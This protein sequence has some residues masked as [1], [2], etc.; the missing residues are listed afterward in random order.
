MENTLF[1]INPGVICG[2]DEAG[3]GPL[4]GPVVAAAVILPPGFPV[5]MLGDIWT[6][7]GDIV[8]GFFAIIPQ[9]LYF[10]YASVASL[11][12]MFQYVFR[13]LA[14]LDVYYVDGT[15]QSGDMVVGLIEGL[16]GINQQYSALST[17]FW[18]MIIFGVIVLFLM[19]I[20]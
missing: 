16:L 2:S 17:V 9:A 3:R 1:D 15:E 18:S 6:K 12:D 10:L 20:N 14:G 13:K 11:L 19:T 8:A 4:A 5:S 7:L